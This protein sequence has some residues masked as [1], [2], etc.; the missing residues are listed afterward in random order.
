MFALLLMAAF[1]AQHQILTGEVVNV[2]DGDTITI[3]DGSGEKHKVRL[4]GIDA[5]EVGPGKKQPGQPFG[6]K[7]KQALEKLLTRKH[8]RV[9]WKE[10]D[11][12]KQILGDV[13]AVTTDNRSVWVNREMVK[14]GFAW[15]DAR[16]DKRKVL[17]DAEQEARDDKRGLWEDEDPT[18]PW[19]WKEEHEAKD[20][21]K[22]K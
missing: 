8:V 12:S 10:R 5:P 17:A 9:E 2:A 22:A 11:D 3:L 15:H 16:S 13:Y 6:T 4:L 14:T 1:G 20:A 19:Q 18:P 21:K 7:S